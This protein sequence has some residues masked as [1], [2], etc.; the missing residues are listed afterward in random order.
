MR[1]TVNSFRSFLTEMFGWDEHYHVTKAIEDDGWEPRNSEQLEQLIDMYSDPSSP[2]HVEVEARV[3]W[4]FDEVASKDPNLHVI[5]KYGSLYLVGVGIGW[6][7]VDTEFL[8]CFGQLGTIKTFDRYPY[9]ITF[10]DP[11]HWDRFTVHNL[12]I[13]EFQQ[14]MVNKGYIKR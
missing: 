2:T 14:K 7:D 9:E 3:R 8:A 1:T 6:L 5:S 13:D 11:T 4:L 10:R 12:T